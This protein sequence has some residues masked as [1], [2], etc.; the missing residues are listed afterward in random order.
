M[1]NDPAR[2]TAPL[3]QATSSPPRC[4]I[5]SATS[6]SKGIRGLITIGPSTPGY[7][8]ILLLAAAWNISPPEVVG[9]LVDH[10]Y[11]TH[12]HRPGGSAERAD[13]DVAVHATY[14]GRRVE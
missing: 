5:R 11:L 2:P 12:I 14:A 8:E 10:Y 13:S 1:P 6:R 3:I 9:R 4:A 7:R